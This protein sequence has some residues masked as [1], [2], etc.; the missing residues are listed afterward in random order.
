MLLVT[1]PATRARAAIWQF[2]RWETHTLGG[3]VERLKKKYSSLPCLGFGSPCSGGESW[4][5]M[6]GA[7]DSSWGK[8]K[9]K[10]STRAQLRW[11]KKIKGRW[12]PWRDKSWT[13]ARTRGASHHIMVTISPYSTSSLAASFEWC[14]ARNGH[15]RQRRRAATEGRAGKAGCPFFPLHIIPGRFRLLGR[16]FL[17][18]CAAGS[19]AGWL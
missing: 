18:S 13:S 3:I 9:A 19:S 15:R 7:R 8:S 2:G 16:V 11:W 10:Q 12:E 17:V 5:R 1:R 6:A 4:R 14:R